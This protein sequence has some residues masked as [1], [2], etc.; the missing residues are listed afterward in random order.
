MS[1]VHPG[2]TC[3]SN[4]PIMIRRLRARAP[5]SAGRAFSAFF[6][7]SR[8]TSSAFTWSLNP[9]PP[10]AA[11]Y[12]CARGEWRVVWVYEQCVGVEHS[13]STGCMFTTAGRASVD[14]MC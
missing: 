7:R 4:A 3:V 10:V 14:G 6:S 1:H 13:T 11:P 2:P 8:P 12:V 9:L 5:D